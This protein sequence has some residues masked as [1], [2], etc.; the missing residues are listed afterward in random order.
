MLKF[1]FDNLKTNLKF[2]SMYVTASNPYNLTL[3]EDKGSKL[4]IQELDENFKFF[5]NTVVTGTPS[6]V[7]YFD[8][9]GNISSDE[10]F[11]RNEGTTI[12]G[13]TW[14]NPDYARFIS[15][16]GSNNDVAFILVNGYYTGPTNSVYT[17]TI[18]ATGSPN[19][20][21][22]WS[23]TSGASGSNI[24]INQDVTELDTEIGVIFKDTNG[25]KIGDTWEA[26]MIQMSSSLYNGSLSG[27]GSSGIGN[28]IFDTTNSI[29]SVNL[30][31][32]IIGNPS[33][34][35]M[36]LVNFNNN[37]RGLINI[38]SSDTNLFE[39]NMHGGDSINTSDITI[40]QNIS[41]QFDGNDSYT[42]PKTNDN[43]PMVNDG[44]GNLTFQKGFN[45][46]Y[47]TGE[48]KVVTVINGIIDS[49]L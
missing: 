27:L 1:N 5:L 34:L 6:Q 17:I 11:T 22:D 18:S 24:E 28:I 8:T 46:T 48:G 14:W 16:T 42:F 37:N 43:G 39:I 9:D 26:G 33:G 3:R 10:L 15:G 49:C 12:I 41:F 44:G 21:I 30:L 35:I 45:G 20:F 32:N 4:T 19:D 38:G 25:H 23:S 47:S 29:V 40:G 7:A 2:K 31:G 36:G 13:E